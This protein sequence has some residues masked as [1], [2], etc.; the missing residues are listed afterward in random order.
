MF[1]LQYCARACVGRP[2]YD[3][4][5]GLPPYREMPARE[6]FEGIPVVEEY[7]VHRRTGVPGKVCV[8]TS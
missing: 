1:S 6:L 3:G 8:L 7:A 4:R 2:A 5:V